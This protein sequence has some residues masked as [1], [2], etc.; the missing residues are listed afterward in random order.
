MNY[1]ELSPIILSSQILVRE[2]GMNTVIN[3][4]SSCL[5]NLKVGQRVGPNCASG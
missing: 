5:K 2:Y 3:L 4:S 1:A